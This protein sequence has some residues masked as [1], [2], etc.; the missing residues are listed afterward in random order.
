MKISDIIKE[1]VLSSL[2][3]GMAK[4][5]GLGDVTLAKRPGKLPTNTASTVATNIPVKPQTTRS[6]KNDMQVVVDK[7]GQPLTIRYG[8]QLYSTEGGR[9]SN[10]IMTKTGKEVNKHFQ[11]VLD[12]EWERYVG[13]TD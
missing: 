3:K 2:V 5:A 12:T 6:T 10:W 11:Q 1:G 13:G 4:G 8:G 7:P 9:G